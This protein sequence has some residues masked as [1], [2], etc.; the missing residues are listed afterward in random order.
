MTTSPDPVDYETAL[1]LAWDRWAGARELEADAR[2]LFLAAVNATQRD[3]FTPWRHSAFVQGETVVTWH[4]RPT[5][6]SAATAAT[7]A[8]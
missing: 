2:D 5:D 7:G 8:D 3:G 1:Q 6:Q 4:V